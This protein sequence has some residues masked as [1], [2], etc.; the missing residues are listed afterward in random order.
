MGPSRGKRM[1]IDAVSQN[2]LNS[3]KKH[4]FW[5]KFPKKNDLGSYESVLR[6]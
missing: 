1:K 4:H 3:I 6:G 2:R 5:H